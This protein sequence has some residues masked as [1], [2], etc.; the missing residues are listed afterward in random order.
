MLHKMNVFANTTKSFANTRSRKYEKCFFL[1]KLENIQANLNF[2]F[3]VA[4]FQCVCKL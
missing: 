3:F 2:D 4:L 1:P